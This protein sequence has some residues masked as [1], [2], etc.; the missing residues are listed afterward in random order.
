[1]QTLSASPAVVEINAAGLDL[2]A[3]A[4]RTVTFGGLPAVSARSTALRPADA[5]E[6][7]SWLEHMAT[8]EAN[9]RDSW[10]SWTDAECWELG[11]DAEPIGMDDGPRSTPEEPAPARVDEAYYL[12]FRLGLEGEDARA[13]DPA[14]A[15]DFTCGRL[16]GFALSREGLAWQ[17]ELDRLAEVREMEERM[18]RAFGDP[19]DWASDGERMEVMGS[20]AFPRRND[21]D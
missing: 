18:E 2:S 3:F 7:R 1:M 8:L 13:S 11:P 14:E 20:A 17:R 6:V 4:T 10:P 5:R 12:G 21:W 19:C 9:P 16:A 15:F